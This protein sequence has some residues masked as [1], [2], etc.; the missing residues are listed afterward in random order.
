MPTLNPHH[1]QEVILAENANYMLSSNA[2]GTILYQEHFKPHLLKRT[3]LKEILHAMSNGNFKAYL[4]KIN[5][6]NILP[7][8]DMSWVERFNLMRLYKAGISKVAYVSPQNI[9]NSLEMEKE[10][11]PGKIF[12]IRIFRKTP[13]AVK[14]LESYLQEGDTSEY[15]KGL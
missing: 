6:G 13:D 14:W 10:L 15:S 4:I 1:L 2:A 9:F 7:P 8:E 11:A 12:H 3:E 5:N